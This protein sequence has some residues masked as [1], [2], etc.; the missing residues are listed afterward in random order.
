MK[1]EFVWMFIPKGS[2]SSGCTHIY[3]RGLKSLSKRFLPVRRL[4]GNC[5]LEQDRSSDGGIHAAKDHSDVGGVLHAKYWKLLSTIPNIRC[6]MLASGVILAHDN[7]RP[8]TVADTRELVEL[9]NWDLYDHPNFSQSNYYPFPY[10]KN[11]LGS[12]RLS[13]NDE[14]I[15]HIRT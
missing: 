7:M 9:F 14:A 8:H 10:P 3:R 11:R 4:D 15:E 5:F 6:G 1:H 13:S 12:K 2:Q